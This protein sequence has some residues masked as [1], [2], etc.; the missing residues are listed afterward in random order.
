MLRVL[1][2]CCTLL[3]SSEGVGDTSL[4]ILNMVLDQPCSFFGSVQCH[5]S[6]VE[7]LISRI[8]WSTEYLHY[9]T[10]MY[11]GYLNEWR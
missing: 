4:I 6:M 8:R 1:V 2:Y 9:G 7:E 11:S 5:F 3:Y 10:Y